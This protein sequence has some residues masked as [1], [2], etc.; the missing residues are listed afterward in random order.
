MDPVTASVAAAAIPS[1]VS[2]LMPRQN[3]PS[4]PDYSAA[5]AYL[6]SPEMLAYRNSLLESAY[7]PQSDIYQI[8]GNQAMAGA[9]RIAASRGL[10]NS[11]AGIGFVQNSQNELARK[12]QEG[13][14]QRR[15]QA[16]QAAI[17]GG[18]AQGNMMMNMADK[19][20]AAQMANYNRSVD[21][22]AAMVGSIGSMT[23]NLLSAY[24]ASQMRQRGADAM[25]GF[26]ARSPGYGGPAGMVYNAPISS[27]GYNYPTYGG[28][29]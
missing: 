3:A 18:T 21:N 23:N 1:M 28:Y 8:A 4:G 29:P 22:D 13:E 7:S 5:M 25:S 14:F 19:N 2:M 27:G 16:Y 15:L 17:S 24:E 12:F 6:N 11:G 9:N 10:G 26:A 20:Y